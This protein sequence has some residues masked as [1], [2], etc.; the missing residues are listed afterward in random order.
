M[1]DVEKLSYRDLKRKLA[2]EII[3]I[4]YDTSIAS[5]AEQHFINVFV[6]KVAP[7]DVKVIKVNTSIMRGKLK[8]FKGSEFIGTIC[9]HPFVKMKFEYDIPI[10]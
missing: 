8:T 9:S 5:Q 2:R 1:I 7:D 3:S 6:K 4:Y 10:C